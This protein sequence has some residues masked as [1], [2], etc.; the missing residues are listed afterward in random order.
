MNISTRI[1]EGDQWKLCV[2]IP[3][4]AHVITTYRCN[5][6]TIARYVKILNEKKIL[7]LAEVEVYGKPP[8]PGN[9]LFHVFTPMRS[10]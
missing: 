4:P 1:D 3:S 10:Y 7:Y 6:K 2:H 5:E 9:I 8:D